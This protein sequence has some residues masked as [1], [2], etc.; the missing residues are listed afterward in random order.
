MSIDCCYPL[1]VV[2]ERE[3]PEGYDGPA[4][5]WD[6]DKTY[7]STHF[8][9]MKGLARIP[10]EF[11]VDK[12]AIPGMPEILRGLRRG[13]GPGFAAAPLYFVSASP[14]QMR[15]VLEHKMLMDGVEYDGITSKDWFLT[16]KQRRPGRLKEQV[17]F[18]L[19]ALLEGRRR[20]PLAREYLFGDDV[21]QDATA[22]HL[23]SR[24]LAGELSAGDA[25]GAMAAEGVK[26]DDRRCVFALLDRLPEKRGAVPRA[27][28]HLE[29]GTPPSEFDHFGGLVAPVKGAGQLAPAL[30]ELGLLDS[31]AVGQALDEV[32]SRSGLSESDR[33]ELLRDAVSRGLVSE[34]KLREAGI[35]SGFDR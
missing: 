9:S 4:F 5:V 31:D 6:I 28:I 13:P 17:G 27:F 20:R 18:K 21:E 30:Y 19:C 25:D 16:V 22:F 34:E 11:A 2:D 24:L 35:D 23:Y 10:L 3:L 1:S 33:E 32:V 29:H 7:L 15:K 8:S 12:M 26:P 14:P